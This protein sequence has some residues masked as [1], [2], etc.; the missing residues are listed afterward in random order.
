MEQKV[1]EWDNAHGSVL[2]PVMMERLISHAALVAEANMMFNLCGFVSGNDILEHLVLGSL[3]PVASLSVP[4]GTFV[5][6]MGTGGGFPGLPFAILHENARVVL[7]DS[8][9]K[10]CDFL[11]V[12]VRRLGI[13]NV[14]VECC[15]MENVGRDARFRARFD[16]V[17][18]RAMAQHYVS[19]EMG[20]PLLSM[21]GCL[22][23]YS[24]EDM[25]EVPSGIVDHGR[26]LGLLP[27]ES[28]AR[29]RRGFVGEGLLFEKIKETPARY[30]RNYPVIRREGS[31]YEK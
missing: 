26:E 5:G 14:V 6:D 2:T 29:D 25:S 4:R 11:K 13:E 17:I 12:V 1:R 31:R 24:R 15:R 7:F 16:L 23:L 27:C 9:E 20:A 22:Y 19:I 3:S 21:G 8:S 18:T 10:K 30:P 28:S